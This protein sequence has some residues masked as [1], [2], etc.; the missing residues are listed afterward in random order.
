[1]PPLLHV[2]LHSILK[3]EI[4]M[5]GKSHETTLHERIYGTPFCIKKKPCVI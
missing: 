2:L 4:K 1:M 3:E 5:K